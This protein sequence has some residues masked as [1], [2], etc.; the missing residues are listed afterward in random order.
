LNDLF[1]DTCNR[2]HEKLL[3][4]HL[5]VDKPLP[6]SHLVKAMNKS[7]GHAGHA[8]PDRNALPR[9]HTGAAIVTC[10]ERSG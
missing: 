7:A 3:K 9:R 8:G 10:P 6:L 2:A 4:M 5:S 1:D